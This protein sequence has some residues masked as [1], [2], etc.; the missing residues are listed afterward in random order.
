MLHTHSLTYHPRYI[1]FPSQY[2]YFPLSVSFHHCSTLISIFILLLLE[3]ETVEV[4]G[5]RNTAVLFRL[6]GNIAW[7]N[8]FTF[9]IYMGL[10][11]DGVWGCGMDSSGLRYSPLA[12][13]CEHGNETSGTTKTAIFMSRW[14]CGSYSVQSVGRVCHLLTGLCHWPLPELVVRASESCSVCPGCNVIAEHLRRRTGSVCD[15]VREWS[16]GTTKMTIWI[17]CKDPVRTV[18]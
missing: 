17:I 4:W 13:Y 8:I 11:S 16:I 2:F 9:L 18:Q 3:G 10:L 15:V 5:H 7:K 6:S 12:G 1:M 14:Y